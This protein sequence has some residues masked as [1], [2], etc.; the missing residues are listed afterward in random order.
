MIHV[1][2]RGDAESS[3][4]SRE[5][6]SLSC[7]GVAICHTLLYYPWRRIVFETNLHAFILIGIVSE[8]HLNPVGKRDYD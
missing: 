8:V 6:D 3:R 5:G 7:R 1:K 2:V 4:V